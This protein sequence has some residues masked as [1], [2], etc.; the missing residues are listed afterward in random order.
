MKMV[1]FFSSGGWE[2]YYSTSNLDDRVIPVV[3][4]SSASRKSNRSPPG[5]GPGQCVDVWCMV[6]GHHVRQVIRS[7]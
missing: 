4:G 1:Q 6:V 3:T 2:R 5:A 7:R